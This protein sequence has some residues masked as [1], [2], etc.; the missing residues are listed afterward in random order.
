M[1]KRNLRFG[2]PS[3]KVAQLSGYT[4]EKTNYHHGEQNLQDTIIGMASCF[5]G[6]NNIPLLYPDGGF[7]TRLE[8]G[9]DA[10]SARYIYT[11]LEA[12][13]H[14]IFRSE[15]DPILTLVNDDGDLVQPEHYIPIVPM[16][17][18]NGCPAG[19][20]T[21]WSCT[22]PCYDPKDLVAT[23]KTW[24][25]SGCS[26]YFEDPRD[27]SKVSL[28][29]DLTPWYRGFKGKI[30]SAGKGRFKTEG[31]LVR[32]KKNTVSITELPIGLW[33][34]KFKGICEDLVV[35]KKLKSVKNYSTTQE[36]LFHLNE[37]PNGV[38]CNQDNMKL[39]SYLYTSNMVLFDEKGKLK[40]YETIDEIIDNFC[41]V[42]LGYY[43]KRKTHQIGAFERQ[44]AHL[45]NKQRFIREVT[46]KKLVVM[47]KPE[48]DIVEKLRCRKYDED[49]NEGGYNYLLRLPVRVFTSD[50]VEEL[51]NEIAGLEQQ[52]ED[53]RGTTETDIWIRE[54]DELEKAYDKWLREISKRVLKAKTKGKSKR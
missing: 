49:P 16:I 52:L 13:T 51:E 25:K 20:G 40:K 26:L 5:V 38:S 43:R 28:L 29:P 2:G 21:G 37:T 8:G 39:H 41:Q 46:K 7:G 4:A 33:T 18:V 44:L 15:D 45:G 3:L 12:L 47:N 6:T 10:A 54:L 23:I 1:R 50:K 36:V 24:I 14:L 53:L 9:K 42:R 22:V 19:I 11:K 32:T 48:A 17:L 35:E 34:D 30:S 27:Q 31:V